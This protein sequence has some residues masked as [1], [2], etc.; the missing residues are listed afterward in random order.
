METRTY[1]VY[2]YNE[3]PESGKVAAVNGLRDINVDHDW[4]DFIYEEAEL[5]GLKITSFE[6]DRNRSAEG[7]FTE[8]P[9]VVAAGI[10]KDHGPECDTFKT[11]QT[12]LISQ[13]ISPNA[14][15]S[16]ETF[17]RVLLEDYSMMLQN[18]YDYRCTDD[19]VIESIEANEYDFKE[20]GEMD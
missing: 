9:E 3:L 19:A 10:I 14:E 18:E 15:A 8:A 1:T 5:L 16:E 2:K 7:E 6:L 11:A 4:W 20:S 17:L 12:Y 13:K